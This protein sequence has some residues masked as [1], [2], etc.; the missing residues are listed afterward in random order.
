[1]QPEPRHAARMTL[2]NLD[3]PDSSWAETGDAS[4][5][6]S[7]ITRATRPPKREWYAVN[8]PSRPRERLSHL[9]DLRVEIVRGRENHRF[10]RHRLDGRAELLWPWWD[11]MR[12]SICARSTSGKSGI[13]AIAAR[14]SSRRA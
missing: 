2:P 9:V 12:C 4:R 11:T 13:A 1:M 7:A 10:D 6:R 8:S 3:A 5:S 14:P